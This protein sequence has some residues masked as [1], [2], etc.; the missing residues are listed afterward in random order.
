MVILA[1]TKTIHGL[2][3]MNLTLIKATWQL[4]NEVIKKKNRA[5]SCGDRRKAL[6]LETRSS[7]TWSLDFSLI[8]ASKLLSQISLIELVF[9]HCIIKKYSFTQVMMLN[10]YIQ[11]IWG[12]E[13]LQRCWCLFHFRGTIFIFSSLSGTISMCLYRPSPKLWDFLRKKN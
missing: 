10:Y 8:G 6:M 1:E 9:Q 11:L 3:N 13:V 2:H 5:E 4:K 12:T 7:Y